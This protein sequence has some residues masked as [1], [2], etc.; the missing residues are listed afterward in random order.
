MTHRPIVLLALA[1]VLIPATSGLQVADTS[2][3]P[4]TGQSATLLPDG[5]WLLLGGEI[6]GGVTDGAAIWD[7]RTQTTAPVAGRLGTARAWHTATVLP[8][9]RVLIVGGVAGAG[10]TTS[11]E[12]FDPTAQTFEAVAQPA[13][14]ARARH[15]ATLLTDGRVLIAGGVGAD[16]TPLAAVEA[17]DWRTSTAHPAGALGAPRSGH[18]AVFLGDGTVLI[19]GGQG[20]AGIPLQAGEVHDPAYQTSNAVTTRPATG[21]NSSDPARL[22]ASLPADGTA[23]VPAEVIIA[24]R[25]SR[26]MRPETVNGTT[27]VLV[28]GGRVE[29]ASVVAAEGG[30]LVFV[31]PQAP[32]RGGVAY[33]LSINGPVDT[34]GFLLPAASLT[35]VT[36]PDAGSGQAPAAP[37]PAE[38][39]VD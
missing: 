27:M 14:I 9:G 30:R 24:L 31:T 10:P 16:G 20:A 35:F 39:A 13:L 17:W 3:R 22:K 21:D 2:P 28:G 1:V 37:P 18:E 19:W 7:P 4:A 36:A 15:T 38:P 29:P 6:R 12:R 11:V 32:L 23:D 5:R 34:A 25:F 33:T 8:D 26:P